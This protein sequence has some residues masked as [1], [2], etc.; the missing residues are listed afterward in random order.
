MLCVVML[1]IAAGQAQDT[2]FNVL[3]SVNLGSFDEGAAEIA[4]YE[5]SSQRLFVINGEN[6]TVDVLDISNPNRPQ[7]INS[8]DLSAFGDAPNSVDA[9]NGLV[10]V[11]VEAEDVD[12]IGNVVFLNPDGEVITSVEAGVLPDALI[13]TADASKVL[14]ANEGEPAD[15]GSVDPEGSVTIITVGN[16][17][18]TGFSAQQVN[19]QAFNGR[20]ADLRNR[21]VRIFGSN[22]VAQDVEPE[23]IAVS[24]DGSRAF[25]ALQE[26]NAFAI[27]DVENAVI[28]DILA[29]GFKDH[30]KGLATLGALAEFNETPWDAAR[31]I[32]FGGLSGLFFEGE[33]EGTY[34]FL[35][36]PDRGPN[37]NPTAVTSIADGSASTIRPFLIPDYQAVVYRF[38]YDINT[39]S[40]A[41]TDTV[42]L[43]RQ[44]GTTPIT[45]LP[46]IPGVDEIPAEPIADA[47]GADFVDGEGNFFRA[48]PY[49]AFGADLEGIVVNPGD[50]T[51]WM[52]DEYRP[53]I[54]H[55][56]QDGVLIDRFVPEGTAALGGEVAGTF[57]EETLPTD[58]SSRRPN[59]GFE[60]LALDTDEGILY[61]FIQTPLQNPDRATSNASRVIRI[62]GINP[63]NGEPVAEYVY[64]LERPF[65]TNVDKIGD[66]VYD[67]TTQ[68][69][70]VI[71]RDS[72]LEPT[73]KKFIF[74]I[75]LRFAT[76]L[77]APGA[78]SLMA[79]KTLEQHTPDDLEAQ[80]I[81][82]VFKLK[83]TNLPTLGYLPSDKPEGLAL[84]PNG[85]LAVLNDND[86]GL[87]PGAE[88]TA[89]GI[90]NF[91]KPAG[92]DASDRDDAINIA[93]WPVLGMYQ[94]DGIA[95]FTGPDGATYF[96]SANEGDGRDYD[97]FSEEERADDL[98]LDATAFPNASDL[99]EDEQIGRL[100]IT[101]ENGDLD[102]DGDYER[103]F[104][105]GGRS[106]SIWDAVGNLV[107]DSGD[108]LEQIT[109]QI[110]PENFNSTNDETAFDNRSDNK[111]PEPEGVVVGEINGILYA[112]IGLERIGGFIVYDITNP[113]AP[114]FADYVNNRNFDLDPETAAAGDLAPEG[115]VFIPANESP[116]GQ[117]IFITSNEVS[118]TVTL[119]GVQ[120]LPIIESLDIIDPTDGSVITALNDGDVISLANFTGLFD[121]AANAN[122]TTKS[123]RF[124]L[125]D[126]NGDRVEA[127]LENNAPFTLGLDNILAPGSYN[128]EV[129]P[130]FRRNSILP[131]VALNINFTVV[132]E[133]AEAAIRITQIDPVNETVTLT[134]L[135][136]SS[137][138]ISGYWLCLGP[139]QYNRV[140]GYTGITGD[141][142]LA[143]GE[144]VIFDLVTGDGNVTA[145]PD[146]D[147]ALGLFASAS[148]S[149]SSPEVVKDFVQ[150][151]A[152][153]QNRVNQGVTAGRWP[154][155]EDFVSGT[156]PYTFTGGATDIGSA[157]WSDAAADIAVQVF[158]NPT[159]A[160][161]TIQGVENTTY[162]IRD[163]QGRV[164][165][166]GKIK[167]NG[168][169]VVLSKGRYFLLNEGKVK[170][171]VVE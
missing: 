34:Q 164:I 79:G 57:G 7:L 91:D 110:D 80:G 130:T 24:E 63:A 40:V 102:G 29:L 38:D 35:A 124:E 14:V 41:V 71:C 65:D 128:L 83:V 146:A 2:G 113:A 77:L 157:F 9:R 171:V 81:V 84:L 156:A 94:P 82:P 103:I 72:G 64:L 58:Y 49:D 60:A 161:I 19:F 47:N 111:G 8:I 48:L 27:L 32:L 86:F 78:P 167:K 39:E 90:I 163:I 46:N 31:G 33:G 105:Y 18:G 53:A 30:S 1:T 92:I 162:E 109:A 28:L 121:I 119:Y 107:Y 97:F 61:A 66:A 62:L 6:N 112:F 69:F 89:L 12:G 151:G 158:P 95:S 141:L 133:A 4:A 100:T 160:Q 147:G 143:A 101:T 153:D 125:F 159:P 123:V 10:A 85:S 17:D 116:N 126:G 54:Y 51:F 5:A 136:G 21:G 114:V 16:P 149:S 142:D 70:Y 131:G 56:G 25:V 37:G 154:S 127:T 137:L 43:F 76:N 106:F 104:A 134:N 165:Q 138:D 129:L 26:N 87:E 108:E 74:E 15:D 132:E 59:R 139:G 55:F 96:I 166:I 67:P 145:L 88:A 122:A 144:Q 75:D 169:Q 140:T 3:R 118:S 52:C 120:D 20:E 98:D 13:F 23:F 150:W 135:G 73:S 148:F 42:P 11:A 99:Q 44:D 155:N 36:V 168:S 152:A 68:R 170:R 117:E 115:L 45:G 93:N 50:N 22:T